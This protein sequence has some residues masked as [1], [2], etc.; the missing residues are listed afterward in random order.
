MTAFERIVEQNLAN[1]NLLFQFS[2][3]QLA[4]HLAY[5]YIQI[6]QHA[7]A[8]NIIEGF[9]HFLK[10]SQ[11]KKSNDPSYYYNMALISALQNNKAETYQY[12]QGA[13]DAG[14]VKVWQVDLEPI[15]TLINEEQQFK[16]M[17]GGIKAR[18]ANMRARVSGDNSFLFIEGDTESDG[19]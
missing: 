6:E 12:I 9:E 14:W 10:S 13:I 5:A 19:F 2:D 17:L 18:L 7:Q 8:Q 16:Q 15:L 4:V 11:T 3:G 1:E